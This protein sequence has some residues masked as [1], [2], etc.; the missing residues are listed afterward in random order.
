VPTVFAETNLS[1]LTAKQSNHIEK[2]L[3]KRF[4]IY[5]PRR[6]SNE[7]NSLAMTLFTQ[8]S[9]NPRAFFEHLPTFRNKPNLNIQHNPPQVDYS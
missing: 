1:R 9:E 7:V 4:N 6:S 8:F 5:I 2:G 3:E